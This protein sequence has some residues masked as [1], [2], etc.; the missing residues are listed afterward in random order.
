[1]DKNIKEISQIIKQM[2]M[3]FFKINKN[4]FI[5]DCG[6][7]TSMMVK[8]NNFGKMVHFFKDIIKMA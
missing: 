6:N 3:G 4:I 5:K 7:K 1:M 8:E 2:D